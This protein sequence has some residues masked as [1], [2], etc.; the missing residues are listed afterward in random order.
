[1]KCIY[2]GLF[3][4]GGNLVEVQYRLGHLRMKLQFKLKYK[5]KRCIILLMFIEIGQN[6]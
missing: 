1:M 6:V 5:T 2:G 4:V 3:S